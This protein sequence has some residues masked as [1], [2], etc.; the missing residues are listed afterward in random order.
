MT[1]PLTIGGIT[2]D[3]P[4]TGDQNW[5]SAATDWATAV[6]NNI[7]QK[8][9]GSF[10]LTGE[11]DFGGNKGLKALYFKDRSA[12][13]S[14]TGDVRLGK[15]GII[16]WRNNADSLDLPLGIDGSDNLIFDGATFVPATLTLIAGLGL[17]GGG[18]LSG[19]DRTFDVNVD[20]SVVIVSDAVELDGDD[21]APGNDFV[22]STNGAGD[23]GWNT[24]ASLGGG[25]L[26]NVVEDLSPELGGELDALNNGVVNLASINGTT[27]PE[28]NSKQT[29]KVV[30]GTTYTA[31]SSDLGKIIRLNA[32]TPVVVSINT[33]LGFVEGDSI[34]FLQIGAGQVS[35]TG[36]AT[37]NANPGLKIASQFNGAEILCLGTDDYVLVG[38]L[39]V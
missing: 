10:I 29:I 12:M 24:L 23:K 8:T 18:D 33:G 9:G 32:A 19:P 30:A 22:Y 20:K 25:T 34:V 26:S 39:T 21:A 3:Y 1:V 31:I 2:F 28:S 17:L 15:T 16:A 11:V 38:N 36:T 5:G 7:L 35:F 13:P 14:L 37:I 6:T 4:E 27:F